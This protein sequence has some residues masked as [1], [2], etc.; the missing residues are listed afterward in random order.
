[1]ADEQ[2]GKPT[3]GNSV[4]ED[5]DELNQLNINRQGPTGSNNNH[6]IF[7]NQLKRKKIK[8][9]AKKTTIHGHRK[10]KLKHWEMKALEQAQQEPC[11][12]RHHVMRLAADQVV[13][14]WCRCKDHQHKEIFE[15]H[16]SIAPSPPTPPRQRTPPPLPPPAPRPKPRKV[17]RRSIGIGATEPKTTEL[18]LAYDPSTVDYDTIQEVIYYRT[19]SGRL[20]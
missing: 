7:S 13:Y 20:V 19:S 10:P 9:G 5:L 4:V 17:R 14:E 11:N 2:K 15:R 8:K 3:N 1:M 12:C 18:A 6:Q 16:H